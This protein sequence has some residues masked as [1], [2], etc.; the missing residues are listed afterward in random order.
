[1]EP[2]PHFENALADIGPHNVVDPLMIFYRLGHRGQSTRVRRNHRLLLHLIIPLLPCAGPAN[3]SR[4]RSSH[5]A[6][7]PGPSRI[8]SRTCAHVFHGA[9]RRSGSVAV[10]RARRGHL[11]S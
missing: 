5:G 7:P 10:S 2:A 4:P 11:S 8:L 1:S 9:T 6:A 3:V